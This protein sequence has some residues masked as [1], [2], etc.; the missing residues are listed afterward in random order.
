MAKVP[1]TIYLTTEQLAKIEHQAS[2]VG[3]SRS[4]WVSQTLLRALHGELEPFDEILLDQLIKVRANQEQVLKLVAKVAKSTSL[5]DV[6]KAA[7][8]LAERMLVE[9]KSRTGK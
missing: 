3:E 5:H 6:Q 8:E 9:A 7:F 2:V 4:A 1:I